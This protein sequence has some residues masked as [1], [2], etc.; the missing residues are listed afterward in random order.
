MRRQLLDPSQIIVAAIDLGA[1]IAL[2][3]RGWLEGVAE[4]WPRP[5]PAVELPPA[6]PGRRLVWVAEILRTRTCWAHSCSATN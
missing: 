4:Y 1:Q 5:L 2:A 6:T 3:D